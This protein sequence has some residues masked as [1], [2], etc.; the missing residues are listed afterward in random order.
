MEFFQIILNG[1]GSSKLLVKF[2]ANDFED[3]DPTDEENYK[4]C[5]D[6]DGLQST[7]QLIDTLQ[8]SEFQAMTEQQIQFGDGFVLTVDG[9]QSDSLDRIQRFY[10]NIVRMKNTSRLPLIVIAWTD[11]RDNRD[12]AIMEWCESINVPYFSVNQQTTE[13]ISDAFH[14]LIRIIRRY[15]RVSAVLR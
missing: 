1:R 13:I 5:L 2:I 14:E 4:K 11:D 10:H 9:D 6:V 8:G 7:I 3:F 15:K 12:A